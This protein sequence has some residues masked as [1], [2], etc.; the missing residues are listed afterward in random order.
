MRGCRARREG[1]P[2]DPVEHHLPVRGNMTESVPIRHGHAELRERDISEFNRAMRE[3]VSSERAIRHMQVNLA[4]HVRLL[5]RAG[6]GASAHVRG[7]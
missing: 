7:A 3:C 2:K 4:G 1:E 5:M 6:R